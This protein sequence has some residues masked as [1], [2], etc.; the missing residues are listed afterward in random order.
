MSSDR[1]EAA[2]KRD[3]DVHLVAIAI[4]ASLVLF[5]RSPSLVAS[6]CARNF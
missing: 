3:L 4:G 6:V 5:E 1:K 2:M